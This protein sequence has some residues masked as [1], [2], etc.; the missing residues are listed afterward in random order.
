[1]RR[2]DHA[3]FFSMQQEKFTV[4]F[5]VRDDKSEYANKTSKVRE[6][7]QKIVFLVVEP[8]RFL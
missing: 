7:A 8:Q 3:P 2:W 6:D 1:M 4:P 5:Y